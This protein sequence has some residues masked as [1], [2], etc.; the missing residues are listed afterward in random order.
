MQ[1]MEVAYEIRSF[2]DYIAG[3]E[4]SPPGEGYPYDL[5]FKTFRDSPSLDTATLSKSFVDGMLA[6]PS[7]QN[8]KITQ[9]VLRTDRLNSLASAL[10]NLAGVLI[11][12]A[13][14]LTS[15][16]PAVRSET[17]MYSPRSS[18][19]RYYLDLV[20]LTNNLESMVGLTAVQTAA[21]SARTAAQN[22]VLWEGHTGLSPDSFGVSIDFTPGSSFS[23]SAADYRRMKFADDTRWPNWLDINP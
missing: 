10:D 23:S 20:D 5:I 1:M 22:A 11:A 16:I 19:P 2:T 15:V 14:D 4:E 7:Y 9:S 18:P 6:V 3:S 12:N 8:R 21:A 17:Q 13:G